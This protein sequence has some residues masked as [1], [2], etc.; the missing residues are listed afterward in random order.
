[1]SIGARHKIRRDLRT[2]D[3]FEADVN[4]FGSVIFFL[5]QSWTKLV[6]TNTFSLFFASFL[7]FRRVESISSPSPPTQCCF[8]GFAVR[9]ALLVQHNSIDNIEMWGG[10]LRNRS[11]V[12]KLVDTWPSVS[13][14]LSKIVEAL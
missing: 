4:F 10:G 9:Q 3:I 13:T 8:M 14:V 11:V 1:M 5:L 7:S 2:H 6:E 12:L